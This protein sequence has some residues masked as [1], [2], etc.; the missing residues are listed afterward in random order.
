MHHVVSDGWSIGVLNREVAALYAAHAANEPSPLPELPVQ[1]AD[2]AAWQRQ[3]LQGR[4]PR[5]SARATGASVSPA[6]RPALDL[7]TDHRAAGDAHISAAPLCDSRCRAALSEAVRILGRTHGCTPFMVLLAAFQ[8]LL[9]RY[10]GQDDLCIGTPIAGRNRAETE[11]LI[12]FF[13]NTLVLRGDLSGDPTFAEL[14]GRVRETA[15]GAYA[16]QDV[17]FERLVEELR[18]QR[19]LSRSPFFQVMFVLQN[20]PEAALELAGL[21]LVP[22]DVDSG[23]SKYRPDP[24]LDGM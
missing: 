20:A 4:G 22:E 14:L 7:P 3:W 1:Y 16:H 18:P 17:P 15:L 23:T 11:G 9:H 8:T 19:D 5:T 24:A 10:S 2:Y 6:L 21:Q 13:V 12:G